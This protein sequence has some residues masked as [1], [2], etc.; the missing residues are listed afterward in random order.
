MSRPIKKHTHKRQLNTTLSRECVKGLEFLAK[1]RSFSSKSE[2]IEQLV[3]GEL[4]D[5]GIKIKDLLEVA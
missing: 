4:A 5:L 2:V 1:T 3:E